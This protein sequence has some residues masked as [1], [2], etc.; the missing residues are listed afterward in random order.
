MVHLIPLFQATQNGN[1]V[2]YAGLVYQHWLETA[3]QSGVF[4]NVLAVL[5][6]RG[7]ADTVQ[8]TSGQHGFQQVAGVHGALGF[9]RAYNGVQLINKEDDFTFALLDFVEDGFQ[10]LLKLTAE[11]SACNQCAHVQRENGLILQGVGHIA[12]DN[13]L[14]QSFGNSGFTDTG[15]A[16][17]HRVVF[18]LAGKNPD[19]V[20]DFI[21]TAD[22]RVHLFASGPF[23]QIGAIAFQSIIGGF[24]TVAGH[25]GV[26]PDRHQH[27]QKAVFVNVKGLKQLGKVLVG[28][29][30]QREKQM[31]H[32]NIVV[33][34]GVGGFFGGIQHLIHICGNVDFT[35]FPAGAGN[36]GELVQQFFGLF[37]QGLYITVHLQ[38]KLGNQ[39]V[40]LGE[41]GV[42][43]MLFLQLHIL[44]LDGQLLCRLDGLQRFLCE[45][46]S[47]HDNPSLKVVWNCLY[48]TEEL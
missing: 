35:G 23:H 39:S 31:L 1:G 10:S 24:R 29:F 46:L 26:A 11:F 18:A 42:K 3:F 25:P 30:Q 21:V 14:G 41:Q 4:F 2:L 33:L 45:F 19:D 44:A 7:S 16:D 37:G 13:S 40:F 5:V 28:V 38:Q 27:V 48:D 15:F 22:N 43:E 17:E 34:H 32:R 12:A 6:Q 9:A 20:S 47:V 36:M 8:L